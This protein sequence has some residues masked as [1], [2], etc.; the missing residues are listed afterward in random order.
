LTNPG[1]LAA[2]VEGSSVGYL[3][4]ECT[5]V[6]GAYKTAGSASNI[7]ENKVGS[8]SRI[9]RFG[10]SSDA[11]LSND[12]SPQLSADLDANG[13]GITQTGDGVE[14]LIQ[15][16]ENSTADASKSGDLSL[17]AGEK[18]AGTGNGGDVNIGVGESAGGD[19]GFINLFGDVKLH[20]AWGTSGDIT[21][22]LPP[23]VTDYT[24]TFPPAQGTATQVLVNDG[25]GVLSW[26]NQSGSGGGNL[27]SNPTA[28][29]G[30]QN[31]T[32]SGGTLSQDTVTPIS[33]LASF[34]WDSSG[35]SQTLDS[36]LETIPT[37]LKGKQCLARFDYTYTGGSLGDLN[38]VVH[39]GTDDLTT[40]VD[41]NVTNGTGSL[42][43]QIGFLCPTSGG[44][45]LRF[46]ST[47]ADAEIILFDDAHLGTDDR[48]GNSGEYD[49]P[50][51]AYTPVFSAG[52]GTVTAVDIEYRRNGP[53]LLV[54]G[55][56]TTGSISG[57]VAEVSLP[58]GL[59]ISYPGGPQEQVA[60]RM[61]KDNT[62]DHIY[63]VLAVDGSS[64]FQFGISDFDT[65]VSPLAPIT[66]SQIGSTVRVSFEARVSVAE[67]ANSGFS[68]TVTL[69]TQGWGIDSR[70]SGTNDSTMLGTTADGGFN[71]VQ[72]SANDMVMTNRNASAQIPCDGGNPSTG[73]TCSSGDE[74]L[75]VVFNQPYPGRFEVCMQGSAVWTLTGGDLGQTIKLRETGNTNDTIV[76]DT[77][78]EQYKYGS[79][80]PGTDT[81]DR[82][83][84][85]I[86]TEFNWP[87][88]AQ[89]TI[90]LFEQTSASPTISL[91][92]INMAGDESVAFK[93]RPLTQNFPQAIALTPF[94]PYSAKSA[95][96]TITDSDRIRT[97]GMAAGA[98]DNTVTLPTAA[99][100]TN[101]I[102]TIT[103]TDAPAGFVIIDGEGSETV[104]GAT[105][106]LLT[107]QYDAMT[108]QS[109]GSNWHILEKS[110]QNRVQQRF[111]SSQLTS[112]T[113]DLGNLRGANLII[114]RLYHIYLTGD[115]ILSGTSSLELA[116]ITINHDSSVVGKAIH[117]SDGQSD[118]SR[119]MVTTVATFVA[120]DST[121]TFDFSLN[122]TGSLEGTGGADSTHVIIV[123]DNSGKTTTAFTP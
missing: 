57:T 112:T 28:E 30:I 50:W 113:A 26:E 97:V 25:S 85:N 94:D 64:N 117:R 52:F 13:F 89:R 77:V 60:G 12:L 82:E 42:Q 18:S 108:I 96:Y 19:D 122:G 38:V 91:N 110:I 78:G 101:R 32:E 95:D 17:Y 105:T 84:L 106:Q 92:R 45:Q 100:N 81:N 5:N 65:S 116:S 74:I 102:I 39:D 22:A 87:A 23:T 72:I 9:F 7:I 79:E 2:G 33:G 35:T 27:L 20:G 103:K 69:E 43:A 8:D 36:D 48:L 88:V 59:T 53:D 61:L 80:D 21:F 99:N 10:A 58:T 109:D 49:S 16:E 41:L 3:D 111:Q 86:C 24:M 118:N 40:P 15:T 98:S 93:V 34:S 63:N 70:I 75:G 71:V 68:T 76:D 83:T 51:T 66:G 115:F 44:V 4:L 73:T 67:Y 31:W 14:L 121:V 56:F 123:E 47:V 114:G 119:Q 62:G 54:R 37:K 1:V 11:S 104:G 55:D 29:G 46:T 90:K 6:A 120:T 107:S